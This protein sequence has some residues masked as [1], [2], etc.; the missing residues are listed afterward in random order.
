[1]DKLICAFANDNGK[2]FTD[3]HFGD[4]EFYD[5]YEISASDSKFIKKIKNSSI[6]GSVHMDEK[7]LR[8]YQKY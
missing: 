7:K 8:E 2:N 6:E 3:K 4:A 1:M 5:I